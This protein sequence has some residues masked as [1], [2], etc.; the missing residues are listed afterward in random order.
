[1]VTKCDYCSI[2]FNENLAV[3]PANHVPGYSGTDDNFVSC[4]LW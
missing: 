1:M 4:N 3:D 2:F